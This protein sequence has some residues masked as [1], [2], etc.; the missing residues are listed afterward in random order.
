MADLVMQRV[1]E[2]LRPRDS[3]SMEKLRNLSFGADVLVKTYQRRDPVK[4]RK[5]FAL[6]SL[7]ADAHPAFETGTDVLNSLK[8]LANHYEQFTGVNP[9][10]GEI[11]IYHALKSI[12]F[13]EMDEQE[14]GNFYRK[15]VR[16]VLDN[17]LP[18]IGEDVVISQMLERM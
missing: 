5:L 12:S 18:D 15:A 11:V 17:F 10:T 3:L 13:A 8:L 7:V 16:A 2:T 9:D 6:C 4:H 14:F 1:G